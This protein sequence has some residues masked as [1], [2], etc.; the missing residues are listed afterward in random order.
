[1]NP[2][3]TIRAIL[4]AATITGRLEDA[5][6]VLDKYAKQDAIGFAEWADDNGWWYDRWILTDGSETKEKV[7]N[8]DSANPVNFTTEQLY[9]LY[10]ESKK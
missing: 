6:D 1:M 4:D 9:E 8:N 10:L 3:E 7:W 5:V 2:H